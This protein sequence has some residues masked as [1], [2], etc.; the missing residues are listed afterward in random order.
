M[1]NPFCFSLLAL[2]LLAPS[3]FAAATFE[4]RV[5]LGF[6][7]VKDKEQAVEYAMKEGL[8]RME[9]QMEEARGTAMIFN[10]AKQEMIMLMPEQMMYM[11]MPLRTAA[12]QPAGQTGNHEQKV[13][14]TGKTE[15]ILGYLCEQYLATDRGETTEMWVTDKLGNFMG[16]SGGGNPMGGMMGGR[17][18]RQSSSGSGWEQ[19]IKGKEGFFPLRVIS[20]DAKGKETFRLE[21]KKI[22]PG[23]LADSLFAPPDGYQKFDMPN[24]GGMNPFKQG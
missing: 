8:V 2:L 11:I 17:G 22:E 5:T 13:E 24:L 20:R 23:P 4:G 10:W 12:G 14:K 7:A 16:V 19:A 15:T 21:A 18:G 9:P 1:K 6:K 3:V